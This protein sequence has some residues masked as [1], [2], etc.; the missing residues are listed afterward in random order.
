MGVSCVSASQ[1]A[2]VGYY[3]DASGNLQGLL[4]TEAGGSWTAAE[5]PLPAAS[6]GTVELRGVSCAS[7][8]QCVAAG[9]AYMS[10]V[11]EGLLLTDSNGSWTAAEAPLL[12]GT[13]GTVELNGV[14]CVSASHC[15]ATGYADVSGVPKGLL[16][17]DS[18][19]S[20]TAAEAPLPANASNAGGGL[21]GDSC[22]SASQC[23]AVGSYSDASGAE[24]GLV[25]TLG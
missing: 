23:A 8:S 22:A 11:Q 3:T 21:M 4:L 25:L 2:A 14:S 24:D 17:T 10:G 6:D 12:A 16:L 15:V 9:D 7:A 13:D 5:A 1:C 19:G 18:G 20:W